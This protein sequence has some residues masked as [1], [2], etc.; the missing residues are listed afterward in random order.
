MYLRPDRIPLIHNYCDYWCDRCAFTSRCAVYVDEKQAMRK[1]RLHTDDDNA[2]L[3]RSVEGA[4]DES[5]AQLHELRLQA[6]DDWL[7]DVDDEFD[8]EEFM[9]RDRQIQD[10]R[11]AHPL[12][13]LAEDYFSQVA[14]WL[15]TSGDSVRSVADDVLA[16]AKMT[17]DLQTAE[18]DLLQLNDMLEIV[19][20]YHTLFPPKVGRFLANVLERDIDDD[21]LRSD[22]DLLGTAKF[23]LVSLDR[24]IVAWTELLKALPEQEDTLLGFLVLLGRLRSGI[25]HLAP[26]A[27]AFIRP[28]FDE[29]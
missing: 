17:H 19:S 26:S 27:R 16:T 21:R 22:Y 9:R 3:W 12:T 20:W 11:A 7:G 23:L 18:T 25:E 14:A 5:L 15:E 1:A 29:V 4:L 24:N 13:K 8:D 6:I 2:A 28:G 10:A